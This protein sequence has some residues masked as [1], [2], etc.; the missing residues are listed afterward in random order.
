[1]K[2]VGRVFRFDEVVMVVMVDRTVLLLVV[3]QLDD[4]HHP[5]GGHDHSAGP[6]RRRSGRLIVLLKVRCHHGGLLLLLDACRAGGVVDHLA[7]SHGVALA[8]PFARL[9]VVLLHGQG[10]VDV[11]QLKVEAAGVADGFALIVAT[12]ERRGRRGAVDAAQAQAASGRLKKK[13]KCE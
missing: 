6:I 7:R 2:G 9:D 13:K 3:G 4:G 12:P 11:V 10:S 8:L 5:S 1:M